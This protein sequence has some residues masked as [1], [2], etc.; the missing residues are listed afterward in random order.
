MRIVFSVLLFSFNLNL[1]ASNLNYPVIDTEQDKCFDTLN[2]IQTSEINQSFYGQD[3]Q[4]SGIE[5]EYRDNENGTITDLNTGLIWQKYLLNNKFTYKQAKEAADTFSLAGYN[6]WRLPTI[7]ELYSLINFNGCTGLN[8]LGSSPFIDT[9]F[10]EF[11]YGDVFGERFIDAQYVSCTE[12]VGF[13]MNRDSTVFGVNF[14]DGRIKGYG[15]T[16]P[17]GKEKLLK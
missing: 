9:D 14:A 11:R 13:T 12:Y 17:F 1:S 10:F 3:A 5:P 8:S 6:D 2:I 7:K 15:I 16:I 4:Y